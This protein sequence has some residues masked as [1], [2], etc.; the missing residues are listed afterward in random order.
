MT[1]W[2]YRWT[3]EYGS[4]D[5]KL[6]GQEGR[7]TWPVASATLSTDRQKVFLEI[8]DAQRVMQLHLAFNLKFADGATVDNFVHGTIHRLAPTSG[9]EALGPNPI[10]RARQEAIS[11]DHARPQLVQTLSRTAHPGQSDLRLSRLPAL[12]VPT[13]TPP[14]SYLDAGPF[15]SRWQGYL[16]LD[17]NDDVTFAFEGTGS[18]LL[19]VNGETALDAHNRPLGST[20]GKPVRLRSGLN[21]FELE[22]AS[23]LEGDAE[24]RL[25]WSSPRMPLEPIPATAFVHDPEDPVLRQSLL[26]REGR[27]LFALH[28]CARCHQPSAP[29]S[30]HAM[31]ELSADSPSFNGIGSR[32]NAPWI[33]Q[34]LL[35]PKAIRPDAL[36]PQLLSGPQA[37]TDA[38]DLAA[39]LATLLETHDPS[40]TDPPAIATDAERSTRRRLAL[41]QPRLRR[42]PHAAR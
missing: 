18:A 41:R 39:F 12:F 38:A 6:N 33:A 7:D 27:R 32:L 5:F 13:H 2:N 28:Q 15:R 3:A 35:D 23:P 19:I 21:R 8:P 17:L 22:Y 30:P 24:F 9:I 20:H 16:K 42:L 11:L 34:W 25:S 14:S 10:A 37:T 40:T 31:P 36:M 4:P 29:W 26:A 1:A